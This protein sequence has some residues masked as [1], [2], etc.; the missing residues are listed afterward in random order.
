MRQAGAAGSGGLGRRAWGWWG[1]G[2]ARTAVPPI[3]TDVTVGLVRWTAV[4]R[5]SARRV[6]PGGSGEARRSTYLRRR[7]RARL[8]AAWLASKSTTPARAAGGWSRRARGCAQAVRVAAA[9]LGGALLC[10][11]A[12]AGGLLADSPPARVAER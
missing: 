7:D 6:S 4:E 2:R 3:S 9:A 1:D 10:A 8:R 5:Y 12:V 11:A